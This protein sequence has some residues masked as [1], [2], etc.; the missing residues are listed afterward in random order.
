[1]AGEYA[2]TSKER[3]LISEILKKWEDCKSHHSVFVKSYERRE[4]S[5]R[6]VLSIASDAAKW[7]HKMHPPYAF[8][9]IETIVSNTVEMG[10]KLD[11]RPAPHANVAYDEAVQMLAQAEAVGDLLRHEHR[12][13]EMDYKQRPLY[14]T[15]AIGG[16]GVGK[17]YWNYTEGSVRR[18]GIK[19]V[20][21]YDDDGNVMLEVPTVTEIHEEGILR[22]HSTFEV[23]D[24][25]DFVV[26]QS[27]KT[28]QPFDPGGAQYVFHRCWYSFEQLKMMERSGF[29]KNVD[30]LKESRS[31]DN[32]YSDRETE[33]YQI[34]R[35]KDLIQVLEYWCMKDGEV[36]RAL[37]GGEK[38]LLSD[39][40]TSP[41]WHGGYPFVICS[42]MP[43]P[44][45]TIGMSDVELIEQLQEMLWE[46]GNQ[47]FDNV[48]Q[49]NNFITLI[50]SEVED[51][52]AFEF[53]P[54]ARWPVDGN[55][56]E[57]FSIL[58]PP[59][60]LGEVALRHM[61]L[62]RGDLQ[63]VTSSAP[64]SGGAETSTVDQKT[65]TG[66][67][68]VMN[69]AQQRMISKKYQAQ[70]CLKQEAWQ[71]IKNCQQ[72]IDG[73]RLVHSIG[74]DGA[75]RFREIDILELQGEYISE[76]EPIGESQMRQEKRG[77]STNFFQVA[78]QALPLMAASG[79]PVNPKELFGWWAKKWGVE[80]WERFFS[81]NP[82]T[83][84]AMA[85]G[86]PGGPGGPGGGSGGAPA[87]PGQPNLGV[88]AETAVDAS[89]PSATGG[90]SMSPA[91]MMQRALAMQNA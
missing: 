1:L 91:T 80:D 4:R 52:D 11:V 43:M 44:F 37:I 51:P 87:A 30:F 10:L 69:A 59:Y 67:S 65:A 83:M 75:M 29:I 5:Y 73:K 23:V 16:R 61:A 17:T 88:T 28:L 48:E 32:E 64:F 89:K 72:F 19:N 9:L 53:Y 36:H 70:Q 3:D 26:H 33:V 25:R 63:N 76:L 12:V 57:S 42:S 20:P 78:M 79:V 7:R 22:D 27:A 68:I 31:H 90:L 60:Q 6:G 41:F 35:Q 56:N 46:M 55:P 85:M 2:P 21:I 45:S 13:D 62:L 38:V 66:A 82:A 15:A 54:C 24:P 86:G 34:E 84:G 81:Q 77:E 58:Q 74:P 49:I 47:T 8:N 14:L 40:E 71:R 39:L 50:R 18:Q